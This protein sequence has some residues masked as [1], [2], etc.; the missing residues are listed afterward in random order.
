[1]IEL[2]SDIGTATPI[3]TG[4]LTTLSFRPATSG[5]YHIAF[6]TD[7]AIVYITEIHGYETWTTSTTA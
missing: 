5:P 4:N 7:S 6:F 1:M 2:N 3:P